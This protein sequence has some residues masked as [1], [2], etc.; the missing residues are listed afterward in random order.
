MVYA[1]RSPNLSKK[2]LKP[3]VRVPIGATGEKGAD[4]WTP[5]VGLKRGRI[6]KSTGLRTKETIR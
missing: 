1:G 4:G 2:S 3:E 6:E 5:P